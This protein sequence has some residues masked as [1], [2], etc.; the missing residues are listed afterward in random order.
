MKYCNLCACW[1]KINMEIMLFRFVSS[2]TI[3][4]HTTFWLWCS[5]LVFFSTLQDL[6][7]TDLTFFCFSG[8]YEKRTSIVSDVFNIYD[9]VLLLQW[10][11][12]FL[13]GIETWLKSWVCNTSFELLECMSY[14]IIPLCLSKMISQSVIIDLCYPHWTGQG[15]WTLYIQIGCLC[16]SFSLD[17]E[18]HGV[19]SNM[20]SNDYA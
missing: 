1:H 19:G 8:L 16:W 15:F 20:Y 18:L 12:I 6:M 5:I 9:F 2:G 13:Q 14:A 17:T 11:L 3:L 4:V 7:V 10:G